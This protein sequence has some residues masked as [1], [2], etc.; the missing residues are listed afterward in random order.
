MKIDGLDWIDRLH[1]TRQECERKRKQLGFSRVEWLRRVEQEA[2][3]IRSKM[4]AKGPAHRRRQN[5]IR[6]L[7]PQMKGALRW[8]AVSVFSG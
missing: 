7:A 5:A 6:Q 1:K 8:K 3:R 2:D 4:A